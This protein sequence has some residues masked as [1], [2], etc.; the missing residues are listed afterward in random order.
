[1]PRNA[2]GAHG[3]AVVSWDLRRTQRSASLGWCSGSTYCAEGCS[4]REGG[5]RGEANG[6]TALPPGAPQADQ[7]LPCGCDS[8][9]PG[10]GVAD[11]VQGW[12]E[13]RCMSR[14]PFSSGQ[15]HLRPAPTS[16]FG[17]EARGLQGEHRSARTGPVERPGALSAQTG[18][19]PGTFHPVRVLYQSLSYNSPGLGC[20]WSHCLQMRKLR[21]RETQ[22]TASLRPSLAPE[23]KA[24]PLQPPF[25]SHVPP[26]HL[27]GLASGGPALQAQSHP[28][29]TRRAPHSQ[30]S[31]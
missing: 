15:Y 21:T 2:V 31:R 28:I 4:G 7:L 1:M 20:G 12:G 26:A 23:L 29:F 13:M 24:G 8:S 14:C 10:R 30:T 22:H 3:T 9:E 27:T 5:S 17:V 16:R 11:L 19:T 25:V 6:Q 18:S